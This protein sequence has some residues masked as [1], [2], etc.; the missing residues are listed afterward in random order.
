MLKKSNNY[1]K[2]EKTILC[3]ILVILMILTNIL[4]GLSQSNRRIDTHRRD[5]EKDSQNRKIMETSIDSTEY[6]KT[7][8]SDSMLNSKIRSGYIK[9]PLWTKE[10]SGSN[11]KIEKGDNS[12]LKRHTRVLIILLGSIIKS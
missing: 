9:N 11:G 1:T 10:V 7:K 2:A 3:V 12:I 8:P 4:I 6:N 5:I